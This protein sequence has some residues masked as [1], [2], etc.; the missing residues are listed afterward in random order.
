MTDAL[1][2]TFLRH[3]AAT[4]PHPLALDILAA[5][6]CHLHTRDGRQVLDLVAG[7]AVNNT[8]HRHQR[9]VQAI[10]DQLDHHLH[11]IPYGEFIQEPQVR[12]AER[13]TSVLPAGLD[14]VYFVSSGT[15]AIEGALKLAKRATGRTRLLG[16][17]K[18]YHGST[19]GSLSLTD[20]TAKRHRNLPL[21][22]DTGH[23][24]FNDPSGLDLITEQVAAVVVE[25]VQGDAG[26]RVP[27]PDWLWALRERCTATGALLVFD[28]V[29]TGFGRTGRLWAADHAGVSPDIMMVSKAITGGYLPLAATLTTDRVYQAFV[30]D[31]EKTFYHGHSYTANPL[32][33]ALGVEIVDIV[34]D[35]AWQEDLARRAAHLQASWR[36]ALSGLDHLAD[37]RGVGF[38]AAATLVADPLT[39][40]AW[41][42]ALTVGHQVCM[43]AVERGLFIRPL[44]DVLYLWP[45]VVLTED[46]IDWACGV[47]AEAVAEATEGLKRRR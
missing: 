28:E 3:L 30:G 45:P 34:G 10:R 12:F 11:V 22:P 1:H 44:G 29:Q 31:Q 15:E 42:P 13:L 19:H 18:S 47:V 17:R 46:E 36:R 39:G 21:L 9:V 23:I 20:N 33:A 8:G 5:E 6:G 37:V 24:P 2:P 40:E 14:R 25:P 16:C 41:D 7:L 32:A 4:S 35:P 27:D 43:K 26:V 38:M